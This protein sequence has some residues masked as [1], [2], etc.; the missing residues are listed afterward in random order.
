VQ[1]AVVAADNQAGIDESLHAPSCRPR[2]EAG[3]V[4]HG[5]DRGGAEDERSDRA[6]PVVFSEEADQLSSVKRRFRHG[7]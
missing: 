4:L 1:G 3:V 7:R 5:L 6:A 2:T